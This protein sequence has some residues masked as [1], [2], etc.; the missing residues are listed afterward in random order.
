[1]NLNV[2]I[3]NE[4]G[5]EIEKKVIEVNERTTVIVKLLKDIPQNVLETI[6]KSIEKG[7]NGT[8]LIVPEWA[9]LTFVELK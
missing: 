1:M 6:G 5:E 4:N 3:Q 2:I 7:L 9:E 8:C